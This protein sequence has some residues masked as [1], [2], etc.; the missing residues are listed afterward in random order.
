MVGGRLR[1]RAPEDDGERVRPAIE[2]MA[3]PADLRERLGDEPQHAAGGVGPVVLTERDR[4][5]DELRAQ[6]GAPA[7]AAALRVGAKLVG[8]PVTSSRPTTRGGPHAAPMTSSSPAVTKYRVASPLTLAP[9]SARN[10]ATS[11]HAAPALN[12]RRSVRNRARI[13][14]SAAPNAARASCGRAVHAPRFVVTSGRSSEAARPAS[15]RTNR[16]RRRKNPST[17][18]PTKTTSGA[19]RTVAA[20][21][22][23]CGR[24]TASTTASERTSAG[25]TSTGTASE[26]ARVTAPPAAGCGRTPSRPERRSNADTKPGGA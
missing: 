2:R 11:A 4:P 21:Q 26:A 6:Q 23:G 10:D 8:R 5:P 17:E 1:R 3:A 9:S 7:A 20:S 14:H 13:R 15:S 12:G 24:A 18:P 19:T 22:S 16:P 25:R